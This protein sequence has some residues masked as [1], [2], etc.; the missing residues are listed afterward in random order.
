MVVRTS[1]EEGDSAAT[2]MGVM[3]EGGPRAAAITSRVYPKAKS[4]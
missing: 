4:E 2:R 3:S 1:E